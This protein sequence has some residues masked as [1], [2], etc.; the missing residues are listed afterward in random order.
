VGSSE[1]NTSGRRHALLGRARGAVPIA[2]HFGGFFAGVTAIRIVASLAVVG[3]IPSLAELGQISFTVAAAFVGFGTLAFVV[4][5]AGMPIFD[6]D[7]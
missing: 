3:K 2:S 6:R 4:K 5:V 1:S 7:E